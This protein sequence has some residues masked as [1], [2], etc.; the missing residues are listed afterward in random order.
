[1]TQVI[2]SRIQETTLAA[3][4]ESHLPAVSHMFSWAQGEART[5][6]LQGEDENTT[7]Y[8]RDVAHEGIQMAFI[9]SVQSVGARA[10]LSS[11]PKQGVP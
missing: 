11:I 1:M 7:L 3:R 2:M 8:N 5:C 6:T 10:E 4:A 9:D